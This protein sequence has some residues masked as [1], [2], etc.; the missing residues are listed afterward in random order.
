MQVV[1]FGARHGGALTGE[2]SAVKLRGG[3]VVGLAHGQRWRRARAGVSEAQ[4]GQLMIVDDQ[5]RTTYAADV[6]LDRRW[7]LNG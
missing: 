2:L 7:P 1:L 4:S 5:S 6:P 3:R